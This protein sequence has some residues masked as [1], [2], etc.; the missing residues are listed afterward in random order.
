M[1]NCKRSHLIQRCRERGYTYEE[2]SE[3]VVHENG[4]D[5]IVDENHVAYPR[6][7]KPAGLG[8][9]VARGLSSIGI[10]PERVSRLTGKPCGCNKRKQHLNE[11]GKKIGIGNRRNTP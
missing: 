10:T 8:D 6:H 7:K 4:D 9:L 5:L 2:V 11:L 3:C 1:I